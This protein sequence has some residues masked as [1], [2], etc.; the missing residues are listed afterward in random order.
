VQRT[1]FGGSGAAAN[2]DSARPRGVE[3]EISGRLNSLLGE[4]AY[5]NKRRVRR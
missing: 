5:P 1:T 2:V 3:V 4:T